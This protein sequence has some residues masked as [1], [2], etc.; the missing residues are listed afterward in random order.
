MVL[1]RVSASHS[2]S[3]DL[4][5]RPSGGRNGWG[6][7]FNPPPPRGFVLLVSREIPTDLPFLG[8]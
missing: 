4:G 6:R 5:H 1:H 3:P 2:A 7:G 8:P